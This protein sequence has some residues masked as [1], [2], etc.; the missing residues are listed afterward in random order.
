MTIRAVATTLVAAAYTVAS[1]VWTL[2]IAR[3]S[4]AFAFWINWAL[5]GAAFVVWTL[6]PIRF[7]RGYYRVHEF[8]RHGAF[9]AVV[10]VRVFQRLLRASRFHGAAPLPRYRPGPAA[11]ETLIAET[12]N[13]ETAHFIIFA[14]L[15]IVAANLAWR[16]WWDTAA[17]L[18]AFNVLFNAYP[19]MSMRHIR[20]RVDRCTRNSKA[21]APSTGESPASATAHT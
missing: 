10:G 15:A 8:E 13:S 12:Y 1:L 4:L 14:V 21:R 11:R 3:R 9:Y 18:S 5:M 17:W 19:V 6:V 16:G 20:A 2:S 7:R